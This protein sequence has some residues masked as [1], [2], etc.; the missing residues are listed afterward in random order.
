MFNNSV[1][2][3]MKIKEE[4]SNLNT[5]FALLKKENLLLKALMLN[6]LFSLTSLLLYGVYSCFSS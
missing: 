1:E 3:E 2:K 5:F 4:V 6:F